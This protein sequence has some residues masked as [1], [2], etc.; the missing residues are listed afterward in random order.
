[1]NGSMPR[2]NSRSKRSTFILKIIATSSISSN[3]HIDGVIATMSTEQ[4]IQLCIEAPV[5]VLIGVMV[6]VLFAELK[7]IDAKTKL[8]DQE[9]AQADKERAERE[10]HKGKRKP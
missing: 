8:Q 3:K 9:R 4:L 10:T 7:R 2:I 5:A 6:I 1:M